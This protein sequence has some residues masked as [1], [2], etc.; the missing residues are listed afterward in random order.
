MQT[1]ADAF[2]DI[3]G[4]W[5]YSDSKNG[6]TNNY[7]RTL[8]NLDDLREEN[9]NGHKHSPTDSPLAI[10][11]A[12]REPDPFQKIKSS[13]PLICEG[14]AEIQ[15]ELVEIL[16][17]GQ[18]SN[19]GKYSRLLECK[20]QEKLGVRHVFTVPN[21]T[22][23]LQIVLSS[24]APR[25][26][27]L[28]PSFTFP[29]TVHAIVHANLIPRLV[30]VDPET[31]NI[32]LPSLR[33]QITSR[34]AAILAVNVFGNPCHIAELEALA[35]AKNIKLFFDSAAAIGTKYRGRCLGSH[36]DAEVFSLS[37]TKVVNAGE[38]GFI[39]TSNDLLAEQ[40]AC[41]RNYGF[42]LDRSD[43]L[44]VG[45]NGKLSEV[46][47]LFALKSLARMEA[48]IRRR[49]AIA[50][51]YKCRLQSIPGLS[52]QRETANGEMNYCNFA[53]RLKE[54]QFGTDS[55]NL[56][57]YLA[58]HN[59]ETKKYFLP[60]HKTRAFHNM[61]CEPLPGS[62]ALAHHVLCLPMH[63]NLMDEQ[64]ERICEVMLN[65]HKSAGELP[66]R[67]FFGMRAKNDLSKS[68]PPDCAGSQNLAE[69]VENILN[70]QAM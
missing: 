62:E 10:K 35:E 46:H 11:A 69:D 42:C 33:K 39:A 66:T 44:F 1:L 2:I 27:V 68:E 59:I 15:D 43:C 19:F 65:F 63:P 13:S 32:S 57:Q 53:V 56:S 31:F 40:I 23:G 41:V 58:E 50:E 48:N 29:A 34:T 70:Q 22:T 20:L 55:T 18:L 61:C 26:E 17:S 24:L 64:V 6:L 37:A 21:A 36:G 60:V 38:G 25:S 54:V 47:A 49:R 8:R 67:Y 12:T 52:F 14:I 28:V 5:N 3:A 30:D 45:C 51:I 7:K 9:I 16:Q 4:P